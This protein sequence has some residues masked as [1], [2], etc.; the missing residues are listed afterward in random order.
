MKVYIS[1]DIEGVAGITA[2]DEARRSSPTYPYFADQ[3]SK[4]VAA[5]CEG[6]KMA[7]ASQI[8]VKDAH[9]SGRNIRPSSLPE[10][11]SLIRGWSGHPYKMLQHIGEDFDAI[12]FIGYHA[13]GASNE[14]P[15]S[16][17]MNSSLIDYMKLNGQYLSEFLLHAYLA[18]YLKIPVAF[19]SGDEAICRE[20]K[21]FNENIVTVAPNQGIGAASVSIHPNR[22]IQLIKNGVK[23]ALEKDLSKNQVD[24]PE[25]FRLE[26][27]YKSHVD[28]Y[29]N[30][31][32]PGVVQNSKRG[33]VFETEDYFEIMR[34]TSFVI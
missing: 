18:A 3:M 12:V 26:I 10:Y 5:A 11:V 33:I 28:A 34:I 14:N 13:C 16:H 32:Y 23:E 21:E 8:V 22:S 1:S 2:W 27:V 30:S 24:L 6:A 17:T 15:L 29:K 20:A 31:F 7:G 19:L 9:G 4:E 25:S